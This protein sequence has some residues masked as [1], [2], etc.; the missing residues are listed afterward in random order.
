MPR[1]LRR[2]VGD[3][4]GPASPSTPRWECSLPGFLP[5]YCHVPCPSPPRR[6]PLFRSILV[7][8]MGWEMTRAWWEVL[9]SL[10]QSL[11]ESREPIVG[12][13]WGSS[14]FLQ[15]GSLITLAGSGFRKLQIWTLSLLPYLRGTSEGFRS[16]LDWLR[17]CLLQVNIQTASVASKNSRQGG[18]STL[19]VFS[20]PAG[21][22][23]KIKG[24][25]KLQLTMNWVK[26]A[27]IL[28]RG[29]IMACFWHR[30][31]AEESGRCSW[32][33]IFSVVS[34]EIRCIF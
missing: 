1:D 24:W 10:H 7:I 32:G 18:E 20:F 31:W 8:K 34:K 28:E 26:C 22:C 15:D 14:Q 25:N 5:P 17:S 33:K 2:W 30:T 27:L 4:L 9:G 6:Q 13:R 3:C 12:Q 23:E 21:V 29:R 19:P 11:G 16:V